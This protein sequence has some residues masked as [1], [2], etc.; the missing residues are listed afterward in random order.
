[1]KVLIT[2]VAGF[3]GHFLT[4]ELANAGHEVVGMDLR[5]ESCSPRVVESLAVDLTSATSVA[6][7]VKQ[8]QP[9]ACIHLG[10]IASPPVGQRQPELM[11]NTNI[12]GTVNLLE[13][14]RQTVPTARVLLASTSYI[15][16]NSE[17]KIPLTEEAPL[18]PI[19]PYALS[20]AAA[21]MTTLAYA[22]EYG[23]DT[24]SARVA[25]H[26]GPG[27][28]PDF[29]VPA[30]ARQVKAIQ[31]GDAPAVMRVGNL[32]SE[33]SF[34]DVRDVVRAYRLLI[35]AGQSGLAYNVAATERVPIQWL[36]DQLC[37][38]A[39]VSPTLEVDPALYRPTDYAPLLSSQRIESAT[40][41][42]LRIPFQ[43]TLR[44]LLES[45]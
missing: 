35:E 25:N 15:Y 37:E 5:V 30:F 11:L 42:K 14:V 9:E 43:Q 27:Q 12:L 45:A 21:D 36:L 28:S 6:A 39:G 40:G 31:Q 33:R 32:A 2:G 20:K 18:S 38:A 17:T 41:W 19:G 16:G 10:G 23:M 7:A 24:M 8:L 29:V 1:M 4:D 26:T 13:A 22:R 44:D 3:V 34:M